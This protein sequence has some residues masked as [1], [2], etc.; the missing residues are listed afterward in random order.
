MKRSL[1]IDFSFYENCQKPRFMVTGLAR[2]M[3][4]WA[5]VFLTY[6]SVYCIHEPESIS[7]LRFPG[8][9]SIAY[10]SSGILSLLPVGKFMDCPIA[11]IDRDADQAFQSFSSL[12]KSD[13]SE[14][15]DLFMDESDKANRLQEERGDNVRRFSFEK[16]SNGDVEEA[17]NLFEHCHGK[18]AFYDSFRTSLLLDMNIQSKSVELLEA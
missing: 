3:T 6:N 8:N 1:D 11:I 5:S 14:S 16:L 9:Q 17:H 2:S 4:A 13:I 15:S 7:G 10:S 18:R 12:F